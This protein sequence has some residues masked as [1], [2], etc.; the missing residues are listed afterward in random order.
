MAQ[1]GIYLVF[2]GTT[3]EAFTY[4]KGVFGTEFAGNIARMGDMPPM[5]GT[6]PLSD[7]EKNYIANIQLPI[8]G[9][10]LLLGNDMVASWGQLTVGNNFSICLMPDSREEA[11]RLFKELGEGGSVSVPL[12]DQFWGDY[13]GQVT[14]KFG[15]A[16]MVNYSPRG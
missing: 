2:P 13:F 16:W 3:E 4:Y 10:Q 12:Q 8:L 14:D 9:G 11:A 7:E 1:F 15:I 6:P 5:E